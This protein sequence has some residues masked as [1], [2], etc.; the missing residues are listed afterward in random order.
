MTAKTSERLAKALEDIGLHQ[1]AHRARKDEFHDYLSPHDMPET[2]LIHL[3]YETARITDDPIIKSRIMKIRDEVINGD[4][5][6]SKEESDEWAMSPEG[7][8]AYR[9]LIRGQ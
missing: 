2:Y 4:H 5:D 6:A 1:L 7:Q 3:L 8:D 9:R